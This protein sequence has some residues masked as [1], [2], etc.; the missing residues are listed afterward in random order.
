MKNGFTILFDEILN[1]QIKPNSKIVYI[2]LARYYNEKLK[3]SYPNQSKLLEKT[4][5]TNIRTLRKAIK[6][7]QD[8]GLIRAERPEER[9]KSIRYHLPEY[10]KGQGEK[11]FK[12]IDNRIF[13]EDIKP[14]TKLVYIILVCNFDDRRG[15]SEISYKKL[16]EQVGTTKKAT[17]IKAI[18]E[19]EESQIIEK[20]E[21]T[22]G[23]NNKYYLK[24]YDNAA[25]EKV[26]GSNPFAPSLVTLLPPQLLPFC[27]PT[28][29]ITNNNT[30]NMST[31]YKK[32]VDAAFKNENKE[33]TGTRIEKD[34]KEITEMK[35]DIE[36]EI[37][38]V[39]LYLNKKAKKRFTTTR[40]ETRRYIRARLKEFEIDDLKLVI[41]FKVEEWGDSNLTW[42]N[43]QGKIVQA[44]NYLQPQTLFSEKNFE[45]YLNQAIEQKR[46]EKNEGIE[47]TVRTPTEILD[48]LGIGVI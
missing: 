37:D 15:Y 8:K 36:K 6:E 44:R 39:I 30:S 7:L 38:E 3:Y 33:V 9:K 12:I 41:D 35:V 24:N 34:D 48:I 5:I 26:E 21:I 25:N 16:L 29:N 2:V 20:K 10:D 47:G 13:D 17:V 45:I 42:Y 19:L 22:K 4:N 23:K 14:I 27:P 31:S 1:Y 40:T 46:K 32:E 11:V 18:R 28:N 43:K